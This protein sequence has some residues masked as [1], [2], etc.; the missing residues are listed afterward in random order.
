MLIFNVVLIW[1]YRSYKLR[2]LAVK[3]VITARGTC[4][5]SLTGH[6]MVVTQIRVSVNIPFSDLS[7]EETK[8][9]T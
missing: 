1:T 8:R 5:A 7:D 2:E 9:M 3:Y 4:N 6:L